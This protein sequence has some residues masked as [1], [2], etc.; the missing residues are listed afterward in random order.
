[1]RYA[2]IGISIVL[3]AILIA[4]G[5]WFL[6]SSSQ[7]VNN[8]G[9]L[10]VGLGI[11]VGGLSFVLS[12]GWEELTKLQNQLHS[13]TSATHAA[14]Q[15]AAV[16]INDVADQVMARIQDRLAQNVGTLFDGRIND[17]VSA[18]LDARVSPVHQEH[19][20]QLGELQAQVAQTLSHTMTPHVTQANLNEIEDVLR[21]LIQSAF[22]ELQGGLDKTNAALEQIRKDIATGS[23]STTLEAI[24]Q[25]VKKLQ[26][27]I[28]EKS[29]ELE[30]K[31]VKERDDRSRVAA[32]FNNRLNGIDREI[33]RVDGAAKD[34]VSRVGAVEE[35]LDAAVTEEPPSVRVKSRGK[36]RNGGG[37]DA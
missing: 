2:G 3:I 34:A 31:V 33:G 22:N 12:K 7:T 6:L 21:R 24:Q 29:A 18:L 1:M 11:L 8:L 28:D 30:E 13:H 16:D 36:G 35:R 10:F 27:L 15:T 17:R 4:M 14:S 32:G 19:A 5:V 20:R 37:D 25:E 9:A 26:Q 23:N